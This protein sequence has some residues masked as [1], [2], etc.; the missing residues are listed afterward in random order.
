MLRLLMIA[1]DFTGA[2]DTGVQLAAHGIPTQVVVG[3]A[4][5]SACSSTVLVVDTETRHLPAAKAAK[6]VEELTR[7]AVENGVG[8][9]YKKTDSALRGN[10]GAELAALLKASGARNLPFL[11]AFPQIGRTTEKGVHY[12]KG[13]PV[14][15]SPF[16]I[17][18][19]EPVRHA[20]VTELIGEQTDVPAHSFPTL[21]EG[22]AVPEQEGILVF[23][24]GSLD[25]LASTGRA[26]FQNGKP[27]LMAGCAGFAALLPDLMKMTERRT[28]TMPK[29]DPR[30]LVVCGSVNSI[31]LR[32]LDVA[33]QNG[34]SR[35]RLTPRQKLDPGY[36]E[37]EDGKEALQGINEMLAANP[38]CIIE[39]N[40]EGGNQPT[41]DYAAAR[42]LDLEGMRVGIASSIGHMLGKLFT[43]PALGTL[44]LTGGDTLLNCVGIKELEPVCEVE[45][46]VVLARFTY[47]GCTRYVIT[48]SGGFGHEK[49]LLDLADRIA[50]EQ[51]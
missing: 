29:L 38:R 12:I 13:V 2:L 39:T 6:A 1:D 30:L 45:K 36:W 25:D 27:R 20:R 15:E 48:K 24:T 32:Q 44:L 42:G 3:Q 49:L 26:L 34:F 10:I 51:T 41:A 5:L 46:G 33:E 37:S 47:R 9:I 18:P 23:D 31:T 7:S 43:S 21:K 17:D 35:L 22:E 14:N 19:F 40:D 11:P 8:C 50:A 16:G 28:V 4:D